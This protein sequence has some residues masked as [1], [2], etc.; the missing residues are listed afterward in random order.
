MTRGPLQRRFTLCRHDRRVP[1]ILWTPAHVSAPVPLVLI[2]HGGSDSK[3]SGYVAAI[4]WRLATTHRIAAVAIDGPVHGDRRAAT[5]CATPAEVTAEFR[6]LW[7]ADG[8]AMTSGMVEDWRAVLDI[9]AELPEI[10]GDTAGWWG[11]SMGTIIGLSLVAA[12]PRI[13]AA[14]LGLMGLMGPTRSR[15]E[16]DAPHVG[17]STLFLLH[18]DDDIVPRESA[19]DLWNAIGAEDKCMYAVPGPHATVRGEEFEVS[20]R[21]LASRLHG[22]PAYEADA[23]SDWPP[24][25][26][27]GVQPDEPMR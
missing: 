18:W 12:E 6:A 20:V 13:S 8:E 14:V 9:L 27:A 26:R 1:G 3:D 11:V 5:T 7:C 4:G 22:K 24:E 15:I 25:L 16:R 10:Q 19:L 17:C 2:G 21:F 23:L